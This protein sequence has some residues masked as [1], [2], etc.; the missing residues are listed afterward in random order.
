MLFR[1]VSQ[2]R[3]HKT[4]Q[5]ELYAWGGWDGYI[6]YPDSYDNLG[7]G[8]LTIN[9]TS[10]VQV[11]S[12]ATWTD[13]QPQINSTVA[14]RS[15]GT[16]WVWGDNILPDFIPSPIVGLIGLGPSVSGS[17]TPT[18]IGTGYTWSKIC[19]RDWETDRKSTRLNSSHRL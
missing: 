11:G 2:S 16:L 17:N 4:P 15:D 8:A 7:I 5:G 1:S 9:T 3:Y 19:Y 10:P 12:N 14:L 6:R 13:V 18:Q